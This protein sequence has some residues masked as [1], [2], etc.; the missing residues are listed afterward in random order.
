MGTNIWYIR[1]SLLKE[2]GGSDLQLL[3]SEAQVLRDRRQRGWRPHGR[4]AVA[5]V[6]GLGPLAP[7]ATPGVHM[8]MYKYIYILSYI[9]LY[10]I[11]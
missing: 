6:V 2:L 3:Q 9:E 7:A 10:Y 8:Y 4:V 1:T 11:V 5:V